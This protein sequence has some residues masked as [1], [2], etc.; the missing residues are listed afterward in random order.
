M[1]TSF[2]RVADGKDEWLTPPEIIRC[3]GEFDLDPCASIVRPWPTAMRH[4]TIQDNGLAQPW[5]GRVWCN[6]PYGDKAEPFLHKMAEHGN[7]ILLLFARTE[8]KMFFKWIWP[9]AQAV[10]FFDHR[11]KFYHVDGTP[12]ENSG[13]APSCLVAY[14]QDNAASIVDSGLGG[15]LVWL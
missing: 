9:K 14:G 3:L 12:A 10:F 11:L 6:P 8:T 13:G 1:N 7:G 2:E 15:K 4:Y 5:I